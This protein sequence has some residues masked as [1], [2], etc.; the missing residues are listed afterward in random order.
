MSEA[1][2]RGTSS[3][4]H[5]RGE[6]AAER[7]PAPLLRRSERGASF[8][9][10]VLESGEARGEVILA[11]LSLNKLVTASDKCGHMYMY[12]ATDGPLRGPL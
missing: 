11:L 4:S 10:S 9:F 2:A 7:C 5:M 1:A 8:F 6:P 12:T 3:G